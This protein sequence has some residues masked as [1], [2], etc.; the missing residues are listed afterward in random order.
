MVDDYQKILDD[1]RLG[2]LETYDVDLDHFMGFQQA[3]M[4]YQYKKSIIGEA[5]RG[6]GAV[7]HF[8]DGSHSKK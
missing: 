8:D 7:Y 2:R 3:L 6:G 1:L 5:K 4:N